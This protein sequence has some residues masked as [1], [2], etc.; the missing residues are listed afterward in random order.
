MRAR[1]LLPALIGAALPALLSA[2]DTPAE[3]DTTVDARSLLDRIPRSWLTL[4]SGKS[5]NRVEGLPV[6]FG[7]SYSGTVRGAI[8]NVSALG[9][10]R[11]AHGFKWDPENVGHRAI[12]EVQF[13]ARRG[14]TVG[15]T[16]FDLVAPVERWQLPEPDAGLAAFLVKRDYL[17]YYGRHGGRVYFSAFTGGNAR[18]EVGFSDERWSSRRARDVFTLF[19]SDDEWRVNPEMDDLRMHLFDARVSVDSRNAEFNPW[20]GWY[21]DAAYER[22]T[23]RRIPNPL[24]DPSPGS[25]IPRTRVT[26]GRAFFDLRRYNRISPSSQLNA[27]LVVGGWVHGD[28]VPLERR[29]SV[30]GIGTLPGFD[31][32]RVGIGTDVGQCSSALVSPV[33]R[34]ALCDRVTLAQVEYRQELHSTLIDVFNRNGIRVRGTALYVRP[35]AVVFADAGRGWLVGPRDGELRYPS[36]SFPGLETFRTDV[37]VGID[38]G[39][40]GL[41]VAKAV[42]ERKEPANFFIRLRNRF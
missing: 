16:S 13:G 3:S 19:H 12:L 34:P 26:Y 5:Y 42:S 38:L 33:G 7:P 30:G 17:D 31:F 6:L 18:S 8:V 1:W 28:Q 10:L 9:V 20:V 40:G 37:G 2:Q 23:G 15:A 35:A 21:I 24:I 29:L 41:Y 32:R 11:S 36:G 14:F 22:G 4:T 27:R 39:M 25:P